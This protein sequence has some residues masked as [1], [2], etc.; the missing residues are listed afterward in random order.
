MT[1]NW[2]G[3]DDTLACLDSL[4]GQTGLAAV[5]GLDIVVVDNASSDDSVARIRERYPDARTI[6]LPENR[7]F[8]GA[9]AVAAETALAAERHGCSS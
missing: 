2:N 6:A 8:A 5:G 9:L 7:Y 3:A 4:A 1:V